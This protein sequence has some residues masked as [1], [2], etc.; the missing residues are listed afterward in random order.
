[1]PRLEV[2]GLG[3]HHTSLEPSQ[4]WARSGVG[5]LPSVRPAP[6][7]PLRCSSTSMGWG[8]AWGI[9]CMA[10]VCKSEADGP[11]A[12]GGDTWEKT[13]GLS[14][15]NVAPSQPGPGWALA[16]L[17]SLGRGEKRVGG[18]RP[19]PPGAPV[20]GVAL[21]REL[22]RAAPL[23]PSGFENPRRRATLTTQPMKN[24]RVPPL[25]AGDFGMRR[26]RG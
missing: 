22:E 18:R 13:A 5:P 7:H 25:S 17:G 24:Q 15:G 9:S 2:G 8:G 1:M 3:R 6:E 19:D 20:C 10:S 4:C 16:E 14:G 12:T 21:E 11:K 26:E 23:F